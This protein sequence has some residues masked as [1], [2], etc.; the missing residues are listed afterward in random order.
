MKAA[1]LDEME[2]YILQ[3]ERASIQELMQRFGISI[4]T[5]RRDLD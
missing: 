2:Q 4:N 5:L 1:R 3:N